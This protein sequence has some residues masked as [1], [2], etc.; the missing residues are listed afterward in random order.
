MVELKNLV[1]DTLQRQIGPAAEKFARDQCEEIGIELEELDSEHLDEFADLVE[2][3]ADG[4]T[5]KADLL[6]KTIRQLD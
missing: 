4:L 1:V 2:E 5:D 6:A 3:N